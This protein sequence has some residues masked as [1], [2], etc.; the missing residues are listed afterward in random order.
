VVFNEGLGGFGLVR[1]LAARA[2][3]VLAVARELEWNGGTRRD[4]VLAAEVEGELVTGSGR[5]VAFRADR[6]DVGPSATDYK[7]GR[8]LSSAKTPET[9]AKHLLDKVRKGRLLQAVAY[10]LA[11]PK[12]AGTGRYVAL[13]P[14]IGDLP[15][16]VRVTQADGDDEALAS[17]FRAS[18]ETIEA[19][20]LAGAAF[21][22]VEEA[23]GREAAHCA[24]CTVAEA[25]RRD[26][27]SYRA[28]LVRL[29]AGDGASADPAIEA[30]RALWWLG[31][32]REDA[33]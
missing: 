10:A 9:R 29:M 5:I 11:S 33:Q 3:P 8:P 25:C 1:L 30:A 12:A 28:H 2:R 15:S 26:D 7:T 32:E 24:W 21:P 6:L 23:D 22:R 31:S 13:R 20:M 19:A 14:D 4:G 17:A 27:S 18:V 16:E